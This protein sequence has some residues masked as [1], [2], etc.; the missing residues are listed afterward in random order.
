[1]KKIF[2]FFGVALI[3]FLA[4][5]CQSG[6]N[7]EKDWN[8]IYIQEIWDNY[9][10][11][12]V[13]VSKKEGLDD[14]NLLTLSN[15][16]DKSDGDKYEKLCSFHGLKYPQLKITIFSTRTIDISLS[17]KEGDITTP[18][19]IKLAK[20]V[21][22]SV[23]ETVTPGKSLEVK[24]GLQLIDDT[25]NFYLPLYKNSGEI[26]AIYTQIGNYSYEY[27][28]DKDNKGFFFYAMPHE[29]K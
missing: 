22:D 21:L 13:E 24:R 19:N 8:S 3:L 17:F 1:M 2:S 28:S 10:R 11:T 7:A 12:V 26:E 9:N 23:V 27:D 14:P 25:G 18:Y 29:T 15:T 4:V 16:V 6:K 5:G 20:I